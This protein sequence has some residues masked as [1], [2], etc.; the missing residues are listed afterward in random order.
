MNLKQVGGWYCRAQVPG[1]PAGSIWR[2]VNVRVH[3]V[4]DVHGA[5]EDLAAAADGADVF[6]C[7]GDLL[8]YLDYDDPG[9]G[10]FA[11]V[12]GPE[13]TAGHPVARGQ[14]VRRSGAL[15]AAAWER[16]SGGDDPSSRM[17]RFP[18]IIDRQYSEMFSAMPDSTLMTFGNVDVPGL[19][20]KPHQ[21]RAARSRR[22]SD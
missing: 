21:R 5:A 17:R 9:Q 19:A 1:R 2:S 16:I 22:R 6:I 10:A 18:P 3:F 20:A 13:I 4:S 8:L 11:E 14:G 12:F 7:L 15:T